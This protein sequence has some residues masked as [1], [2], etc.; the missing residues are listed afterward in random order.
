MKILKLAEYFFIKE[1]VSLVNHDG[2][3]LIVDVQSDYKKYFPADPNGFLK[4]L[5]KYCLDFPS[6]KTDKGV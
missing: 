4:K 1:N 3:L 5:D 2:I 6:G